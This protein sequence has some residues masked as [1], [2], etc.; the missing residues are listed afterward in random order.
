MLD[1][2]LLLTKHAEQARNESLLALAIS[3]DDRF[4]FTGDSIGTVKVRFR[5]ITRY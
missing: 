1:G 3:D 5:S 4:L 2:K